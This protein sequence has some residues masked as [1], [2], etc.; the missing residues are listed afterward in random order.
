MKENKTKL[1][2]IQKIFAY[3][4]KPLFDRLSGKYNLLVLHS[5]NDSGIKQ[6]T[7]DYARKV[8]GVRFNRK[9]DTNVFLCTLMR[10]ISFR[11]QIVIHEFALGIISL[12]LV[13]IACKLLGARLVLWSHGYD[14]KKGFDPAKSLS[15]RIRLLY[16]RLADALLLYSESDR[17]FLSK[18]INADKLF[19][20]PNTFDTDALL[21]IRN[22]LSKTGKQKLGKMLGF[23]HRYN[24]VYIGR[25][26]KSK[27]PDVLIRLYEKLSKVHG[28]NIGIHFIGSGEMLEE[29]KNCVVEKKCAGNFYFHGPVYDDLE[30]GK[31]LYASDLM[32]LPG[33]LGLSIVHSFCFECPVVSFRQGKNGPY[34]GPEIDYVINGKTG[35]LADNGDLDDLAGFICG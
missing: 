24:L 13:I 30:T 10:I 20:A 31:F 21:K 35:Y 19:V 9:N 2:V 8:R 27:Y 3:Y 11:P 5:E 32:V 25:L 22:R 4:R 26:L 34:H 14:R 7:A 1:V 16:F 28:K 15:D 33:A 12:P 29:L 6:V 23:R 17:M 18:Y